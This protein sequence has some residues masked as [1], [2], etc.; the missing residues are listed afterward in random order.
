[1]CLLVDVT[2]PKTFENLETWR[3]EFL[4]Q[5]GLD[6]SEASSFPF[7]VLGNKVDRVSEPYYNTIRTLERCILFFVVFLF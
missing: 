6:E 1:M 2:D 4:R 5:V 7:V 3:A